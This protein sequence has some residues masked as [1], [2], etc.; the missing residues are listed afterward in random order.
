MG[1]PPACVYATIY[2]AIHKLSMPAS[3]QASLA[4]YKRYIDDGIGI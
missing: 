3:F 1:P 4:I 2:F